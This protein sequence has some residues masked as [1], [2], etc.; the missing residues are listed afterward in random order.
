MNNKITKGILT[1]SG[2]LIVLGIGIYCGSQLY[3]QS[4]E[5]KEN[6][7]SLQSLQEVFYDSEIKDNEANED[8]ESAK[9]SSDITYEDLQDRYNIMKD[10]NDDYVCWIRIKGTKV[11]YPVVQESLNDI[12]FYLK[13]NFNKRYSNYGAVFLSASCSIESDNLVI[14]AHNMRNGSMFG[15]LDNYKNQDWAEEHRIIEITTENQKR[16]YEVIAV[17]IQN[18]D[19]P[20]VDWSEN[21]EFSSSENSRRYAVLCMNHSIVSLGITVYGNN[22]EQYIT[23]STCEYTHSNGRLLVVARRIL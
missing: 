13:H 15:Q 8:L 4:I 19:Y 2:C 7:D 6:D 18:A 22:I 9:L 21:T 20:V 11:D 12:G 10:I 14:Q 1:I 23:L 17:I 16:F 3:I 5:S